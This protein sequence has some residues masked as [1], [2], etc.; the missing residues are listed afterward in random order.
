[1]AIDPAD[2][3]PWILLPG[4]L[5]SGRIFGAFLDHLG[6]PD[7]VR[8]PFVLRHPRIEDYREPL[9][10]ACTDNAVVCG[11]SLGA[12][13]AA[14]LADQLPARAF[15]LF[16]LNPYA[17]RPAMRDGRLDLARDVGDV[18]GTAALAA[19]LPVL[20]GPDRERARSLIL[21]MADDTADHIGAQTELALTRPGA[22][23]VL[24]RTQAPVGLFTGSQDMSAPFAMAEAAAG[25]APS[26]RLMPLNGL[27][28][29]ALV[30]DPLACRAA[31]QDFFAIC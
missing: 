20:A 2:G 8:R 7:T 6:V 14:H 12:I 4:T 24:A 30:E 9:T 13:V 21:D 23:D 1:M 27:G 18:G 11:F 3:R 17:D 26:G 10:A 28:H 29:Y 25:A 16:G 5:C 19:R 15:L 22:L 31:V